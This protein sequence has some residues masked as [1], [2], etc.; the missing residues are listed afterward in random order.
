MHTFITYFSAAIM[1]FSFIGCNESSQKKQVQTPTSPQIKSKFQALS[2]EKTN[3]RF[4]NTIVKET[5]EMNC[6]NFFNMYNGGGVAIGDINNDGLADIYFTGNQVDNKLYLNTGNLTFKDITTKAQVSGKKEWT[7]GVIMADVNGDGWLDIYVCQSGGQNASDMKNLLFINNQDLTF[8]ESA[9]KY[10]LADG[11]R[12]NHAAFFDYDHDGDLD[13]Y[14]LNHPLGFGDYITTRLQKAKNPSDLE[15]DKLFRNDGDHF[16]EVTKEAGIRNYGFGLSISPADYNN[17]GWID[18]FIANDYSEPDHLYINNGNG[19]FTDSIHQQMKHISQFSMG[20]SANDINNDG[21]T[22]LLVLDMMAEDNKR[23]KTNMQGMDIQAFYTNYA[24][25]RHLQ[26]MQNVLQLNRGNGQFSDIGELSGISNTDWSWSPLICDLD[27]DGWKDIYITNGIKRDLRNNDFQKSISKYSSKDIIQHF[28][29]LQAQMP[30][31]PIDN[32]VYQNNQDL[33]FAKK[34]SDWGLNYK[35]FSNGAGYADFDNDGDL[36]LVVNNMDAE[37]LIFENTTEST[38]FLRIKLDG[39][40]LNT[41]G[42]GAKITLI[43]GEQMQ[44]NILTTNH[45]FLSSSEPIVHFGL[46]NISKV[47]SLIIDWPNS[48]QSIYV[49]PKINELLTITYGDIQNPKTHSNSEL[50]FSFQN[51]TSKSQIDFVHQEEFYEDYDR[52]ILLPHRYSQNGP[53]VTV[54]DVNGDGLEDFFV[55]GAS[56]HSGKLFIQKANGSFAHASSQPWQQHKDQEDMGVS[57]IDIDNDQDLDLY[58]ASGSNEWAE[59]SPMYQDRIYVND[60]RGNFQFDPTLLPENHT[61]T[62]AIAVADFDQ[63][64]DQDIF[65]GGRITPGKYPFTPKS[66][67]LINQNGKFMDQTQS[68]A[69]ELDNLGMI[70]EAIWADYDQDQDLDLILSGEW[71]PITI[72]KN[73]SGKLSNVTAMTSLNNHTGWWYSVAIGDFDNDGDIDLIGGNLGLNSKYQTKD[74]PLEVYAGDLDKNNSHDIILGYYS[75]NQCF[76]LRGRTCSSQQMPSISKRI[77]TYDAFGN[78][79]LSDV[80]GKELDN[81]F[82]KKANWLATSYFENIG[83]DSFLIHELPSLAQLS[84]TNKIIPVDLNEDGYLDLVIGGNMYSAEIETARHDASYGLVLLGTG[85]SQFT[86]IENYDSHLNLDGDIK[87]FDFIKDVNQNIQIIATRNNAPI[88][89]QKVLTK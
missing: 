83:N 36:D 60:G 89:L 21:L 41:W 62:S 44:H 29:E 76:P 40:N 7:T 51:N 37:A 4:T 68:L 80:Y 46:G 72:M 66:Y 53:F 17:D 3:I 75:E 65:V 78:S 25:G 61:S 6:F 13:A 49:N 42:I 56:K 52:E 54:G 10:G 33:T 30:S 38:N 55:G 5:E 11:A 59:N 26:Y 50:N 70:T 34:E 2:S 88:L 58:V 67:L 84:T 39:K 22:D 73:E 57:F 35:G 63:D 24:L 27:N 74:G 48:K 16:T 47:D 85:N 77:P 18:L 81:A 8:T 9:E 19:T 32:Y 12:S 45:G 87:D 14:I 79:S 1:V 23:K 71:M 31:V 82:H 20:S 64:G 69:P 28:K 43:T 15:T 86:P